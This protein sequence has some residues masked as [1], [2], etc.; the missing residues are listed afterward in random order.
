MDYSSVE[1]KPTR[2]DYF[3]DKLEQT[4]HELETNADIGEFSPR[5]KFS[6]DGRTAAILVYDHNNEPSSPA[7]FSYLDIDA[8]D[9]KLFLFSTGKAMRQLDVVGNDP[10]YAMA[11][12]PDGQHVASLPFRDG[13]AADIWVQDAKTK[14]R[15][16]EITANRGEFRGL[17]FHPKILMIAA[18]TNDDNDKRIV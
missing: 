11:L 9:F 17:A 15:V 2:I 1:Y 13:K 18:F 7:C 6:Y 14:K 16:V 12:S 4:E 10:V 8:K 5:W 3:P